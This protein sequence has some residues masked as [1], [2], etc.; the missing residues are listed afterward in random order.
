M[1][2]RN[3]IHGRVDKKYGYNNGRSWQCKL[4]QYSFTV[5]NERIRDS[6]T[7]MQN[8]QRGFGH[9]HAHCWLKSKNML[10]SHRLCLWRIP[11]HIWGLH[12][13][14]WNGRRDFSTLHDTSG[15][16]LV[17][18]PHWLPIYLNYALKHRCLIKNP[19]HFR[20]DSPLPD[21]VSTNMYGALWH[22]ALIKVF[23]H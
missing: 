13:G 8:P 11:Y 20:C 2:K 12:H 4:L 1:W 9:H 7:T 5:T 18:F 21:P 10:S 23:D 14:T 15:G 3:H 17:Y 16:N 19:S 22:Q 6:S